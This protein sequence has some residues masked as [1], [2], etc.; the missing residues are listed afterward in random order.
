MIAKRIGWRSRY[1]VP[2]GSLV[3]DQNGRDVGVVIACY[4]DDLESFSIE[5]DVTEDAARDVEFLQVL[6]PTVGTNVN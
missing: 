4:Q 2:R 5:A 6:P 3:M 1:R